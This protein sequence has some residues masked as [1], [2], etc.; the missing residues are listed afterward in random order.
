MVFFL[1]KMDQKLWS[2]GPPRAPYQ[3]GFPA[4]P[5][6]GGKASGGSPITLDVSKVPLTRFRGQN[7][8]LLLVNLGFLGFSEKL[9]FSLF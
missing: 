1:L 3:D 2:Q 5:R 7:T 9:V 4:S 6:L 8:R